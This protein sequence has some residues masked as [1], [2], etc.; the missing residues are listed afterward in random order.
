MQPRLT[1]EQLV[2]LVRKIQRAEGTE[3]ELNDMLNVVLD[4]IPDPHV[5]DHIYYDDLT[6]EEV[7][8]RA[9]KYKPIVL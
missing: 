3:D 9:F 4:N 2:E 1:R 7:V 8:E 5:S 6:P